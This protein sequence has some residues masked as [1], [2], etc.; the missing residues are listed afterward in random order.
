MKA[1]AD[2]N[3][4]PTGLGNAFLFAG[5]NALSFQIILNSPMILFAKSIGASATVLGIISGMMPL[6]VIFQ[7]PAASHIPKY[8]YK[9][10]VYAGW[11]TRVLFIFLMALVPLTGLFLNAATQLALLLFLLFCFN[12][13]RGIS[14][15]AWLPWIT[16]LV[17]PQIRGRYL[18]RDAAFVNCGSFLTFLFAAFC[19]GE[20]PKPWQFAVAFAFSAMMGAISLKFLKQIPEGESPEQASRSSAPVPW[21]EIANYP[22][23]RKLLRMNVAWSVA[24]G[25]MGAFTVAF[26]KTEAGLE[27]NRIL[28][29]SSVSF[30]GGLSSLWLLGSRLDRI[31]SKPVLGLTMLVW[32]GIALGWLFLAGGSLAITDGI[33]MLL[34]FLMGLGAA[35]VNMSNTRLAMAIVPVM[36]RSHFFA[37]FSVAG[38]LTLGISPVVWGILIDVFREFETNINGFI[39]S[40]YSVFFGLV[41]V[42]FGIAVFVSRKLEEPQAVRMEDLLHEILVQSPQ[43]FWLK[44]WPRS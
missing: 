11:G 36:G 24:Y 31:G 15:S 26:L 25:G 20:N 35:V 34:Q 17:P 9:R 21:R 19:L 30:L 18:A 43:R 6:L 2:Q 37:L 7:I 8:G 1:T 39:W 41:A 42:A 16:S 38:N 23:F 29:L 28:A 13:S 32:L 40:R 27:E 3:S 22:P 5:F 14:S 12:L 44:L 33:V 4:F 10:F